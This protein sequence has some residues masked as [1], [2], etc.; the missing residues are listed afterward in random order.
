MV[1][2]I[3]QDQRNFARTRTRYTRNAVVQLRNVGVDGHLRLVVLGGGE[4]RARKFDRMHQSAIPCR[5]RRRFDPESD[6]RVAQAGFLHDQSEPAA[7]I[8]NA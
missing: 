1:R 6:S 5:P 7:S 3:G 4:P 8:R 2:P